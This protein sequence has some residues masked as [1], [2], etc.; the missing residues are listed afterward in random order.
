MDRPSVVVC[1]DQHATE[2]RRES[3]S[4]TPILL[5][6]VGP[7]HVNKKQWCGPHLGNFFRSRGGRVRNGDVFAKPHKRNRRGISAA[8]VAGETFYRATRIIGA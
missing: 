7:V 1:P 4:F 5:F 6:R 2:A 8:A 3:D